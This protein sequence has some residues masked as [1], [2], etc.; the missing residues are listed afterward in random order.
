MRLTHLDSQDGALLRY[1][2][3][4][5]RLPASRLL[6]PRSGLER[7]DF[8]LWPQAAVAEC[9]LFRRCQGRSRHLDN[10]AK[11]TLMTLSGHQCRLNPRSAPR[12]MHDVVRGPERSPGKCRLGQFELS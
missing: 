5:N 3:P 6:L 12:L 10:G 7:S 2:Y 9:L 4:L 1:H 11:T 8:V